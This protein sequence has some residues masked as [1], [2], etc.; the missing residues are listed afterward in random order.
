MT[1]QNDRDREE[2]EQQVCNDVAGS[3]GDKLS[4]SLSALA[5]GVWQ[6]LPI[7]GERVTFSE[8]TNDHGDEGEEEN[9]PDG[10]EGGLVRAHP[11]HTG[12]TLEK[13]EDSKLEHPQSAVKEERSARGVEEIGCYI[14]RG[15]E[16][17]TGQH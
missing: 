9:P 13:L 2:D 11:G 5:A 15:I 3:H 6:N 10:K 17:P 7:V 8:I 1:A 4:V 16:N 14:R 12:E